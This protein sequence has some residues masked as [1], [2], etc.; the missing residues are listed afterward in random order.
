MK[1]CAFLFALAMVVAAKA[2]QNIQVKLEWLNHAEMK[3][4]SCSTQFITNKPGDWCIIGAM[5]GGQRVFLKIVA[6]WI[7]D[8]I[9]VSLT[10]QTRTEG[11]KF[12]D[13]EPSVSVTV[14]KAEVKQLELRGFKYDI[15]ADVAPD[16]KPNQSSEPTTTSGTS[17][18]EQHRVPAAVVAHL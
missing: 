6:R 1:I 3:C 2:E 12:T 13:D 15:S 17:A 16:E 4:E 14:Q 5:C 10:R 18:A 11:D 8:A 9:E 7:G